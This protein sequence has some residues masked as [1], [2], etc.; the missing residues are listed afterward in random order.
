MPGLAT[1]FTIFALSLPAAAL[2]QTA[3]SFHVKGT[4]VTA[5]ATSLTVQ[6]EDGQT[7]TIALPVGYRL[8]GEKTASL[9]AVKPGGFVGIGSIPDGKGGQNAVE[10][11]I[12]PPAMAGTGEGSYPWALRS[13]GTMTNATVAA[14]VA[15]ADGQSLSVT[16]K[17]G[18]RVIAVP[19]G[20]PVVAIAP[21]TPADLKP[22][23]NVSVSGATD[24]AGKPMAKFVVVGLNGAVP[25]V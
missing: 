5:D 14:T 13:D 4:V 10:V 2:A 20:T 16:Y 8:V 15:A 11:T 3:P 12:F 1:V 9:A 24:A 7:G 18:A 23:A 6:G 19:P 17:G 22:G 21:A 25:P